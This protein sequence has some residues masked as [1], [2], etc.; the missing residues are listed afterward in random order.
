MWKTQYTREN[1][2]RDNIFKVCNVKVKLIQKLLLNL[3]CQN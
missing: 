3:W 2:T 1:T